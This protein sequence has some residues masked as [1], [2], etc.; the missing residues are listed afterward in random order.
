[1][2]EV[3]Q[4][5]KEK[6]EEICD[7]RQPV[8]FDFEN[9]N[10]I[11]ETTNQQF[12]E[13]NYSSFEIKIRN[14]KEDD[15]NTE[16][17]IPLPLKNALQLFKEDKNSVY[18]SE[19]NNDFLQETGVIKNMSYQDELMRPYMVSNCIYD[20][21]MGSLNTCTPFRYEVNYRNFFLLTEG[22]AQI[23][24]APPQS[25]RY[26]Y[27]IYDYENFEFRTPV[28]P[29]SPQPKYSVEFDKVKCLEFTLMP[30]KT[31]YIPA[32]WWYS[33]R[34]NTN[35]TSISC[36]KYRT[37]MNNLAI[38]PY[39]FIYALQIQNVKRDTT[40][41]VIIDESKDK[42]HANQNVNN[43]SNVSSTKDI[44]ETTEMNETIAVENISSTEISDLIE[45]V[46]SS[47]LLNDMT[48]LG[49]ELT[50]AL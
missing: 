44:I 31:L 12:I 16:L 49:S 50:V 43:I 13:T 2:Y 42:E 3:D 28:N 7:L 36:F 45:P 21:I 6:L 48:V 20:I 22:S 19:N 18:L 46:A 30:G 40:K 37:Y 27:P 10:K 34:L 38:T 4:C 24:L 35:N 41:K 5:S 9:A 15:T 26:L 39:L 23:K 17:F 25:T 29:W 8:L 47:S 14:M 1:M 33:I 11:M 32:Y